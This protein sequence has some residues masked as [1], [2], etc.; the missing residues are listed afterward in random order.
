MGER[1]AAD[2][3]D[4]GSR[5]AAAKLGQPGDEADRG[6]GADIGCAERLAAGAA[7]LGKDRGDLL[8][9]GA[10]RAASSGICVSTSAAIAVSVIGWP[11]MVSALRL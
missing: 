7:R 3:G 11:R 1:R 2:Q 4:D 8:V 5:A 10:M 9:I 6:G